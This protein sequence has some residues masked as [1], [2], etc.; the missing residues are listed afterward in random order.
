MHI[1]RLYN[2]KADGSKNLSKV[3]ISISFNELLI[4]REYIDKIIG[5]VR[6]RGEFQPDIL[7]VNDGAATTD[8][9]CKLENGDEAE[10]P[11]FN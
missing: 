3:K 8:I 1:Y 10:L 4:N 6:N 7:E 11:L 5:M 2:T 9:G